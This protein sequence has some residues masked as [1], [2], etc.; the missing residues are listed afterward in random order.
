MNINFKN[1]IS[2][3]FM[4]IENVKEFSQHDF[5][6]KMMLANNIR[7]L[8]KF[9]YEV[10]NDKTNLLY[11]ISGMETL[12]K[13][14]EVLKM[15][16]DNL[17]G[18]LVSINSALMV[19]KEYLLD[20]NNIIL[21]KECI[22]TD[23]DGT[24]YNFCYYPQYKGDLKLEMRELT[25]QILSFIDY[26]DQ[27]AVRLA[28]YVQR[29]SQ[30]ENFTMDSII[31]VIGKIAGE[32]DRY[33][34]DNDD[35]ESDDYNNRKEEPFKLEIVPETKNFR[36]YEASENKERRG[37]VR[38]FEDFDR[39]INAGKK[40]YSSRY[41]NLQAEPDNYKFVSEPVNNKTDNNSY[42]NGFFQK[43]SVYFK[44]T[45]PSVIYD[46]IN[47]L[48]IFKKI[49]N[50]DR[51]Q[52]FVMEEM[53]DQGNQDESVKTKLTAGRNKEFNRAGKRTEKEKKEN[54]AN[55]SKDMIEKPKELYD[56]QNMT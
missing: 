27:K 38:K 3:S 16:F 52:M 48:K 8:L 34:F 13:K 41:S 24:N 42:K 25:A 12:G 44:T 36:S 4:V 1:D 2:S 37:T 53:Q 30:E 23:D 15:S 10:I 6:Y 9:D 45:S 55:V 32:A 28:Y 31:S 35:R 40:N 46:D 19:L 49:K 54:M 7:S 22:F 20:H 11:D 43:A 33:G 17:K 5:E 39:Q 18:L 21:K 14:F 51:S 47:H 29:Q 56:F 50:I 26:N